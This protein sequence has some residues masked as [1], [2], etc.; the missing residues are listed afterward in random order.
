[1]PKTGFAIV[2]SRGFRGTR[3]KDSKANLLEG[4]NFE[5]LRGVFGVF[6]AFE[7]FWGATSAKF[8]ADVAWK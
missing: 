1:M 4:V 2:F 5:G 8:S 7:G 3:K 6:G